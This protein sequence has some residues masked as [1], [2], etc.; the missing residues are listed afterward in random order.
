MSVKLLSLQIK[1]MWWLPKDSSNKIFGILTYNYE[2]GC[3][4]AL[5]GVLNNSKY[6]FRNM[7]EFPIIHG[8]TEHG[9]DVTLF[10]TFEISMQLK[11]CGKST[12]TI[13]VIFAVIGKLYLDFKDLKL[14]KIMIEYS[15]FNEWFNIRAFNF[16]TINNNKYEITNKSQKINIA[17][18]ADIELEFKLE[19]VLSIG[20]NI[21]VSQNKKVS[22]ISK[23]G[24][25]IDE[26]LKIASLF[27]KFLSLG[28]NMS[29]Y[30]CS[31]LGIEDVDTEDHLDPYK[32]LYLPN[33]NLPKGNI[34][35]ADTSDMVFTFRDIEPK[36]NTIIHSWMNFSLSMR[37]TLSPFFH[38]INSGY[39]DIFYTFL[40]MVQTIETY[41]REVLG[42]FGRKTVS[43]KRIKDILVNELKDLKYFQKLVKNQ[44]RFIRE[45]LDSRHCYV[46]NDETKTRLLKGKDLY[47]MNYKLKVI[48]IACF[49]RQTG[50][51]DRD[52]D[53]L[54][55]R[56]KYYNWL[57]NYAY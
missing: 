28:C 18:N 42:K 1:G 5:E 53:E 43:D 7:E 52:I 49:L 30:P 9:D 2:D 26:L 41:S 37:Q 20:L 46:H 3:K 6:S 50:L 4:L 45:Y 32:L 34:R 27:Q 29:C 54:L 35:I 33:I 55:F 12:S 25:P 19:L 39:S 48:L 11:G 10:N 56:N 57:L 15:S 16:Q 8:K 24:K 13:N 40:N 44:N 38:D 14:Q 31:T 22:I 47:F 51:P 21:D 36:L 23:T 17:I